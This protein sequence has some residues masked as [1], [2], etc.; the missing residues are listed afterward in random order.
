MKHVIALKDIVGK[1]DGICLSDFLILYLLLQC[2]I[3]SKDF[4][5]IVYGNITQE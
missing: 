5:V 1:S 2:Y 4:K 3:K